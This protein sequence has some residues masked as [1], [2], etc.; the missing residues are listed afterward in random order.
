MIRERVEKWTTPEGIKGSREHFK[1]I[2]GNPDHFYR[3]AE[4]DGEVVGLVHAL[5]DEGKQ[6]LGALYINESQYGTGLAQRL[7]DAALSW[8]DLSKLID[9]EV[10]AYN[11]RAIRFYEKNGFEVGEGSEHLFAEKMMVVTMMRKGDEL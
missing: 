8:F 4:L 1:N 11:G 2:F 7:M 6:H 10:V 9:L 5:L 3:V